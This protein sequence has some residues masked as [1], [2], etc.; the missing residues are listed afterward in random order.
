ML[1]ILY[2]A[3]PVF[4]IR[5]GTMYTQRMGHLL[6]NADVFMR[7]LRARGLSKR[8]LY[9]FFGFD[10][11][12]RQAFEMWKRLRGFPVRFIESRWGTR[13]MFAWRPILMRTRFW[14]SKSL[15]TP[16]CEL[17][18]KSLPI[19]SLTEEE[20][21]KGREGLKK[22]GIGEHDWF[23]LFHARDGQFLRKWRPGLSDGWEKIDFRNSDIKTHLKAAEHIASNGG[24]ALRMGALV[25]EALPETGN[26]RII[27]YATK[28]RSDFM[29]IY[30]GAKCRFFIGSSSGPEALAEVFNIPLLSINQIP[31]NHPRLH[32]HSITIPRIITSR[33]NGRQVPFWE[34]QESGY[35]TGWNEV[36]SMHKNMDMFDVLASEPDDI[37]DGVKDMMDNLEGRL[38]SPEARK[39]QEIYGKL[40]FSHI[41]GYEHG[42]KVGARFAMKYRHLIVPPK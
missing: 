26:S 21:R 6:I 8:T 32:R 1:P 4:R 19:L 41:P 27:D 25:E 37:L 15:L 31:Y 3:E 5:L 9:L 7:R 16:E 35:Y 23:A 38:P 34:A 20:E 14:E 42:G 39:I 29:D 12:N 2:A 13:L 18:D 10:P 22:M 11:V 40:Y 28:Y 33:E 30:L 17:Y 36:S 24:Y